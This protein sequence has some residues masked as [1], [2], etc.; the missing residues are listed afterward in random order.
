[1][2]EEPMITILSKLNFREI[3]F[4]NNLHTTFLFHKMK[5]LHFIFNSNETEFQ[6]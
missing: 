4:P 3:Y 6:Y 2:C 1:M 5:L